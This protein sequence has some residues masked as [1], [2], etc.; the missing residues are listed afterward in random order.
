MDV[1][2]LPYAQ[3]PVLSERRKMSSQGKHLLSSNTRGELVL[4]SRGST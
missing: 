2:K 1:I 4:L 3:F